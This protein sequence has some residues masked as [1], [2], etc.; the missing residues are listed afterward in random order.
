MQLFHCLELAAAQLA[1]DV[2]PTRNNL[3]V[4]REEQVMALARAHLEKVDALNWNLD[5]DR[6][7]GGVNR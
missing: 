6:G 7:D 3:K 2:G 5:V 4:V 1:I